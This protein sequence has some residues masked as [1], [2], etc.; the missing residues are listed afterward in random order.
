MAAR[1]VAPFQY[2]G[3]KHR[4]APLVWERLGADVRRYIEPFAGSLGV[5]LARPGEHEGRGEV[6][7][8]AD[9]FVVNAWRSIRHAPDEVARHL[10]GPATTADLNARHGWIHGEGRG[11]VAAVF[12]D[13]FHFDP[14][15]AAW[16]VYGLNVAAHP[17]AFT[18]R[19]T[20][21]GRPG[22]HAAQQGHAAAWRQP[23]DEYL[24][25]IAAR[26]A[27]CTILAGDWSAAVAPT[28]LRLDVLRSVAVFL[29]P[30][31]VA[32]R[33]RSG[34]YDADEVGVADDVLK[35]CRERGRDP[36]LRIALAGYEGEHDELEAD[37]WSVDGWSSAAGGSSRHAE[38]LWFSPACARG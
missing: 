3:A 38:R 1:T 23:L 10:E 11:R 25:G 20:P 15:V 22:H 17:R 12:T 28:M 2:A 33:R 21:P 9:G 6:I 19:R 18:D 35:W 36:R 29:D 13:P 32:A 27:R 31:Y 24:G 5:L 30:P 16:W 14:L 26:L 8:D 34:L 37:G 4:I 7:N